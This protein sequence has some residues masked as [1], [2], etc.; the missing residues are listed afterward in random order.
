MSSTAPPPIFSIELATGDEGQVTAVVTGEVDAATADQLQ[1]TLTGAI[2]EASS[3]DVDL[4]S[5][6]F[7]DSSGLRALVVAM[8]SAEEAGVALRI[9]ATTPAVDRLLEITG[10]TQHLT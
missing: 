9:T 5:V 7:M 2:P 1:N 10:L 8:N 4:G 3:I 6:N